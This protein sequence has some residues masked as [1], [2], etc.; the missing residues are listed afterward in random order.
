MSSRNPPQ[1]HS[2]ESWQRRLPL[3][4][5]RR[6]VL[7]P[8]M[9]PD[10]QTIEANVFTFKDLIDDCEHL[11]FGLGDYA[12]VR[13]PLVRPHSECLTG[14]V[15]GSTRCDCGQQLAEALARISTAGGFL[16]YLRQEG[17]GIGL[18]NKIDSYALQEA[19]ADT[20]EANRHLGF[21]DDERSYTV[22]AQ[23]LRALQVD[24][25]NLLTNNPD[26]VAQLR[27][28][29]VTVTAV[30]PTGVFA[31]EDNAAYLSAKVAHAGH[32]L[33]H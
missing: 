33:G 10:G 26:K 31:T 28:S 18:Y 14:D 5:I 13:T 16:I 22:V 4:R 29:G 11:A 32:S 27:Q 30:F 25:L 8:L 7:L 9:L 17:R 6:R 2:P 19:G 3:A 15:F 12:G 23:M 1:A 24:R 21:R 20:F